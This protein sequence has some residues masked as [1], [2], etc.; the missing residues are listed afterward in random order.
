MI[1]RSKAWWLAKARLEPDVPIHAG[2]PFTIGFDKAALEASTRPLDDIVTERTRALI[3]GMNRRREDVLRMGVRLGLET[4]MSGIGLVS[5][6]DM[7]RFTFSEKLVQ[8]YRHVAPGSPIMAGWTRYHTSQGY[9]R[10][11]TEGLER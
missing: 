7:E 1:D 9:P 11:T 6:H 8:H 10:E 3:N 5:V 4:D 2:I